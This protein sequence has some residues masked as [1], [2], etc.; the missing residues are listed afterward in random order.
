MAG[1]PDGAG[2]GC[3]RRV[4]HRVTARP[5][6]LAVRPGPAAP[7]RH[8]G[9]VAGAVAAPDPVR[10]AKA[11]PAAWD[12]PDDTGTG[13]RTPRLVRGFWRCVVAAGCARGQPPQLVQRSLRAEFS[14]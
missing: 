11:S 8:K 9:R 2:R 14:G 12:D 4:A 7:A 1:V 13:T 3:R 6:P 5:V 10:P